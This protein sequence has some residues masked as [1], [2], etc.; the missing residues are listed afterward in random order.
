MVLNE[1]GKWYTAGALQ[2]WRGLDRMGGPPSQY[3]E[4]WY[5][6]PVRWGVL[7]TH[8]PAVGELV[9]FFVTAGNQRNMG[10]AALVFERSKLV[11]I[12]FPSDAGAVY[13]F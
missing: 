9:G 2:F 5:Y 11:M 12:P 6:D 4:H 7:T 8:Q 3:A 13:D 1:G 10:G